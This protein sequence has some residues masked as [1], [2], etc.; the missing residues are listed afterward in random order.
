MLVLSHRGEH[1]HA[2]EN[3][4]DAF[5]QALD[6]GVDGIETDLRLSADGQVV[7]YHDRFAPNG[8]E[9]A[10][11][12]R[13]QLEAAATHAV[14]TLADALA[15]SPQRLW[16]LEIKVPEVADQAIRLTQPYVAQG[17]RVLVSSFWHDVAQHASRQ[18]AVEG[19][20]LVAHRPLDLA[21]WPLA[22]SPPQGSLTTIVWKFEVLDTDTVRAARDLGWKNWVYAVE[23]PADH[24][25]CAR[26][27][28]DAVISDRVELGFR[29]RSAS[30]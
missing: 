29:A 14:P 25:L 11:L 4:L 19:G 28:V 9:V 5:R 2:P 15:L 7:L 20:L 24:E 13:A 21:R 30:H 3:T 17:L 1:R 18:L 6:A 23:T 22:L 26:W 12:S 8:K 27:G 16:N 10:S